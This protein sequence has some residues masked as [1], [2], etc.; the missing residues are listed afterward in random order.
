MQKNKQK[1]QHIVLKKQR[2]ETM[3]QLKQLIKRKQK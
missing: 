1:E 2:K 3:K